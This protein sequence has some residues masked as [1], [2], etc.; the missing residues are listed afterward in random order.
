MWETIGIVAGILALCFLFSLLPYVFDFPEA[1]ARL[2]SGRRSRSDLENRL[3]TL[4][5][6]VAELRAAIGG[7]HQTFQGGPGAAW[8]ADNS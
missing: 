1:I 7:A 6:Q 8:R 3:R 4:E 5:E 2:I